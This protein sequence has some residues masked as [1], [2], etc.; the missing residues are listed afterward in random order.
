MSYVPLA[1]WRTSPGL[2]PSNAAW[3]CALVDPAAIVL[4]GVPGGLGSDRVVA[5]SVFTMD[6]APT[7]NRDL[8]GVVG[9]RHQTRDHPGERIRD[10]RGGVA[11]PDSKERVGGRPGRQRCLPIPH[12]GN[13]RRQGARHRQVHRDLLGRRRAVVHQFSD[14][15]EDGRWPYPQRDPAQPQRG[16]VESCSIPRC[17]WKR[18]Q[19]RAPH[20]RT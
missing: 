8:H 16:E 20:S 15:R 17:H 3:I 9:A 4:L 14:L 12:R 13:G 18:G 2:S 19:W 6:E 1:N 10:R 5:A 11:R 7:G